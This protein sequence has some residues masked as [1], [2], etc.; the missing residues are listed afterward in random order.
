MIRFVN[1][2]THG[3]ISIWILGDK[4]EQESHRPVGP[5]GKDEPK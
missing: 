4:E 3:G 2:V 1:F 5:S